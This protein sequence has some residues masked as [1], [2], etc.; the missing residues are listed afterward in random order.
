MR[1]FPGN[2]EYVEGSYERLSTDSNG[3]WGRGGG[4]GTS[5]VRVLTRDTVEIR[6][7]SQLFPS[8]NLHPLPIRRREHWGLGLRGR[9]ASIPSARPLRMFRN[10]LRRGFPELD[11]SP[12]GIDSPYRASFRYLDTCRAFL[13]ASSAQLV[14]QYQGA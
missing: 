13:L 11:S 2:S 3:D 14:T 5:V 12:Q 7:D 4:G 8:S 9:S 6:F 10:W 1:T